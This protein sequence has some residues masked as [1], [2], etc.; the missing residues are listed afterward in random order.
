MLI[1]IAALYYARYKVTY[2]E[3]ECK[4]YFKKKVL[5]RGNIEPSTKLWVLP[6][7]PRDTS[8]V[9]RPLEDHQAIFFTHQV[10]NPYTMSYNETLIKYLHQCLLYPPKPTLITAIKCYQLTT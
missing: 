9:Q 6:L 4:V 5:W 3:D 7:E 2:N 10:N 1:S 8:P